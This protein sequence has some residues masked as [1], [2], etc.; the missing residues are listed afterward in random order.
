M[1][2]ATIAAIVITTIGFIA[3]I[4]QLIDFWQK[5]REKR[6][7]KKPATVQRPLL[8]KTRSR[9]NQPFTPRQ[10][11]GE[12]IETASFYGRDEE[13]NQLQ[14][15]IVQDYCRLVAILGIGG[16][17][18]TTLSIK[19]GQQLLATPMLPEQDSFEVIIWRSLREAPPLDAVLNEVLKVVANQPDLQVPAGTN[20]QI[21]QLL[22]FFGQ[23]RCLLILD[24]GESIMQGSDRAGEYRD[25]YEGYGELFRRIGGTSH[26]SCLVLTSRENPS[27]I[28]AATRDNP[29]VRCL[30]LT[31]LNLT[32]GEALFHDR[33]LVGTDT[34]QRSLIEFYQGNPLALKIVA[35]TIQE[36]FDG[37][38]A[39][40]LDSNLG[41]FGDIRDL[42][43]QQCD[44]LSELERSLMVWLAI[45]RE[46]VALSA[47]RDSLL[48]EVSQADLLQALQSLVRRSLIEKSAAL[49]TLQP[50]VMEYFTEQL[51]QQAT[52]FVTD[53]TDRS[54]ALSV[55]S[56]ATLFNR[57][58]LIQ[59]TAKDYV[60]DVQERLIL[61]P[62]AERLVRRWGSHQNTEIRLKQILTALQQSPRQP[63]Y[64]GG[65][66][67]N[68]LRHLQVDLSNSDFSN[69]TI[70]QAYL[71]G[72]TLQR[73]NFSDTDLAHCIFNEAFDRVKSVAFSPDGTL[74]AAGDAKGNILLWQLTDYQHVATFGGHTDTVRTIAFS[75]SGHLIASGSYDNTIRLWDVSCGHCLRIL[76]GHTRELRGVVFSPESQFL[77]SASVDFTVRLWEVETGQCLK[78]LQAHANVVHSVAFSPSGKILVSGGADRT[79]K[80]WE[81]E[82]GQL[83]K[84]LEEHTERVESVAFSPN[85]ERLA[86]GSADTTVRLWDVHTGECLKILPG[87]SD[88]VWSVTFS[89]NG[90]LLA[91]GSADKT[92]KLWQVNTGQCLETLRGHIDEVRSVAF[93]PNGQMLASSSEELEIKLWV[94]PIGRCLKTLVG[95]QSWV[96]AV[97]ISP[98]DQTLMASY[99]DGKVRLWSINTG[100]CLK[101]LEG[102][103]DW[104]HSV[105][106]SPD[107]QVIASGSHDETIRLWDARTGECFKILG[108]HTTS[109]ISLVFSPDGQLLASGGGE[110]HAVKLWDLKTGQCL[111]TLEGH[112]TWVDTIAFSPDGQTL[113]I[114]LD[115]CVILWDVNTEKTPQKLEGHQKWISGVTFSPDG[116]LLVS[117]GDRIRVWDAST[118]QS[119]KVISGHDGW[120]DA[121]AFSVDGQVLV[122]SSEDHTI[123]FWSIET[124]E[125]LRVL[126]GHTRGVKT[127][128]LTSDDQILVSGSRADETIKIWDVETGECLDTLRCDRPYE[129]MNI[130][131]TT[132]LTTAQKQA[133]KALGAIES[134]E[135]ITS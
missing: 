60:R 20:A 38:I 131:R 9:R 21:T 19:A 65:N 48:A 4:I 130:T 15:W 70:W 47:L 128:A 45:D 42:L 57:Y 76:E 123:R 69:L 98:D 110:D 41:V 55:S 26:K 86:S 5:H 46:P 63:G 52:D 49:F 66:I 79:I 62:V 35:T 127:I 18:K 106:I 59:A 39:Q 84:T 129:G 22:E 111:K 80:F 90:E 99:G 37:N 119:L 120:V 58:A 3:S 83:L 40:F 10:D 100:Q 61:D 95:Y 64:A 114:G 72:A 32:A 43:E 25:G 109:V 107:G 74:L 87:H 33:N 122:S 14:A 54:I 11:W 28:A 133:L 102:H 6:R 30:Q 7:L 73:T 27:E 93:S 2:L 44:R 12:A 50:V 78:T 124:G 121:V 29:L 126:Q 75:P 56:A 135:D 82:T 31:G 118:G 92:V 96:T 132:G 103:T 24:N 104:V 125:C 112:T 23:M 116:Q 36:L 8:E 91:S 16:V 17:G 53:E 113:A 94:M 1:D 71:Q 115:G 108:R 77:A 85:G 13:L 81:V 51:I 117:C 88:W 134:S 101:I 97:V 68:L 89:P 67:L 34:H 105:V